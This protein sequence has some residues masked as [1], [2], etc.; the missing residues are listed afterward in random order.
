[1]TASGR[2]PDP[3]VRRRTVT[4]PPTTRTAARAAG[5]AARR[6]ELLD[7]ADRAIRRDGPEVSME[8]LAA[9]A[10]ITKPVLYRHFG[11]RGGLL[12]AVATRHARRLTDELRT[13]MA[14]QRHPRERIRT[15][16][17]TYLA[18]LDRDPE[19]HRFV[20]RVAPAER[21][22]ARSA[23]DD[24][25]TVLCDE[26]VVAVER[27]LSGA[28]LDPTP[29]TTWGVGMVGMVQLVADRW[30]DERREDR[31]VLVDRLTDLLWHGFR[32]IV[33]RGPDPTG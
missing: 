14:E 31:E 8:Q 18:F 21:P 11:D 6:D 28:R 33:L 32:G 26:V 15:V 29:A 4:T 23:I 5:R 7:A 22:A 27:E 10:G 24:A 9:E 30:L 19:L 1:M 3:H 20:T 25:L 13:S 17:A 16:V 2:Q 12:D